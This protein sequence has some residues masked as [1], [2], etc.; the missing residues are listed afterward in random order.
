[1]IERRI[2]ALEQKL[3]E[4]EEENVEYEIIFGEVDKKDPRIRTI[5]IRAK[6][7][8]VEKSN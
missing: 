8:T 4:D 7:P 5:I 6:G 2:Q 3:S 1:M